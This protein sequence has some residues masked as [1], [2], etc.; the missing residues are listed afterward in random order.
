MNTSKQINI[1]V[2]LVFAAVIATAAYTLWDPSRATQAKDSQLERTVDRGAYLFSQNCRACHGNSGEGGPA[3]SRLPQ[4]FQL[5]RFDLQGRKKPDGPVDETAKAAAYKLI[6]NTL[7]CGRVGK[8]MPAWSI[9]QGGTLTE[10]QIAQLATFITE[11][12]GWATARDYA[13]HGYHEFHITGDASEGITLVDAVSPTDTVLHLSSVTSLGNGTRIQMG[14]NIDDPKADDTNE[15]MVITENPDANANTVTVER[16]VGVT[17]AVAHAAGTLVLKTVAPANPPTITGSTGPVC[18]QY[19]PPPAPT[20]AAGPSPTA[21]AA[22]TEL[23]LVAKDLLFDTST[24]TGVAGK[25]L[26]ITLDNQDTAIPHNVHFFNGADAT[27]PSIGK[28]EINS[29]PLTETLK[30]G[31]LDPGTYYYQCDVHPTTMFGTLTVQ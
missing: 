5:D 19:P 25:E 7:T 10:E 23:K 24:L 2:L 3:S 12:T 6:V 21:A 26:T 8:Y 17:K 16:H 13:V 9:P 27:A 11:G 30:I 14:E 28:T 31:P 15:I 4:A 18:G 22:S 29:G 1:M 20:A